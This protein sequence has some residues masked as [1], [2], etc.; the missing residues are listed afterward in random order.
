MMFKLT[1]LAVAVVFCWTWLSSGIGVALLATS[2][3]C[4]ILALC[5]VIENIVYQ[6]R[7]S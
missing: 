1:L 7:K 6:K 3:L 5:A 4:L 2:Y